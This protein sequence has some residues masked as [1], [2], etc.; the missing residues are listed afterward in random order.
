M[1]IGAEATAIETLPAVAAHEGPVDCRRLCGL[2][3]VSHLP[4]QAAL[5]ALYRHQYAN[6][7]YS[8]KAERKIACRLPQ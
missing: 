3:S 4:S 7:G 8:A 6:T 1:T 2:R 5:K